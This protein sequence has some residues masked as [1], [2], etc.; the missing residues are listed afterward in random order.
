MLRGPS[1]PSQL[2]NGSCDEKT[3]T[4]TTGT[5]ARLGLGLGSEQG[6]CCFKPFQ[7]MQRCLIESWL[8]YKVSESLTFHSSALCH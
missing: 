4:P 2:V 7:L 5:I 8:R 1:M 3:R 6:F